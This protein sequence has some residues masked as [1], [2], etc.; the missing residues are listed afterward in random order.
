MCRNNNI[1]LLISWFENQL[2]N[3]AFNIAANQYYSNIP[4]IGY[5]GFIVSESFFYFHYPTKYELRINSVPNAIAVIG[6]NIFERVSKYTTIDTILAPSFRYNKLFNCD[7]NYQSGNLIIISLPIEYE[8]SDRIL[9]LL[10][11]T[12]ISSY[13]EKVVINQTRSYQNSLPK[14]TY[15]HTAPTKTVNKPDLVN[16]SDRITQSEI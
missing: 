8:T 10:S 4:S 3:R 11:Q 12:T 9:K 1:Q 5:Q 15:K 7:V 13:R 16:F 14:L 2:N 6:S